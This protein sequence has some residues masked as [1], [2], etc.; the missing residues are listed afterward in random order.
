MLTG[1]STAYNSRAV[2]CKHRANRVADQI[3]RFLA[4]ARLGEQEVHL[5]DCRP[6]DFELGPEDDGAERIAE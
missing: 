6:P 1:H 2:L 4:A 5:E 3:E